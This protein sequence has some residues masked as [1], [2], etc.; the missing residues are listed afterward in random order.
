[1]ALAGA[2]IAEQHDRITGLEVVAAGE[3]GDGRGVDGGGGVEVEV[4]EAFDAREPCFVDA[5]LA[6]PF[7]ALIDFG[8]EDVGEER[9]IRQLRS[10]RVGR[11]ALRVVAHDGEFQ[12][13]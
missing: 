10:L 3:R 13:S 1:M 8:G 12:V 6:A 9:E 11:D 4:G 2:G 7:G 5:S